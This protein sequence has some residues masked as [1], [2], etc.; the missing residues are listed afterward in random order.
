[1]DQS[2]SEHCSFETARLRV[3]PWHQV[4]REGGAELASVIAGLLTEST[5]VAL[6]DAWRGHY[7]RERASEWI[8]ERDRESPT[9][10]VVDRATRRPIGLVFLYEAITRRARS[11]LRIGYLFAEAVWGQGLATEVVAG[12]VRW[13]QSE[14]SIGR[15]TAGVTSTNTASI[16]VLVK[17]EFQQIAE[18]GG[19]DVY[20]LDV[21]LT[22]GEIEAGA[23]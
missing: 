7:S 14:S 10:L 8:D 13:T 9:L 12:L 4:P 18:N 6:P 21:D 17:N 5:T 16:R 22:N 15:L 3:G 20:Q 23:R 2:A 19:E 11:E 1:M